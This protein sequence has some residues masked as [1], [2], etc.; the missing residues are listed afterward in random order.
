MRHTQYFPIGA[1]LLSI[2]SLQTGA[3]LAKT[4]FTTVGPEGMS[5][6]RVGIAAIILCCFTKPWRIRCNLSDLVNILFLG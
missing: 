5:A 6:L 1:A 4:A 3:A 2:I